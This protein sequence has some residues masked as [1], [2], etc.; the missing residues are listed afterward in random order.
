[1]FALNLARLYGFFDFGLRR[2]LF[3]FND[4]DGVWKLKAVADFLYHALAG[5]DDENF[6]KTLVL[7]RTRHHLPMLTI[8]KKRSFDST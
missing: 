1:M 3:Y 7:Q 8:V 4:L 5:T 2:D 6:P